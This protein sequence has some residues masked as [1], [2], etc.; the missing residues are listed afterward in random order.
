MLDEIARRPALERA[1]DFTLALCALM[2]LTPLIVLIALAIKVDSRGPVFHRCRRVGFRGREL[3]MLKFR[4][5]SATAAGSSLTAADDD[6]FTRLGRILARTKLDEIPQLFNVLTGRMS[7]VGPRPEDPD[8]VALR[9]DDYER[10][11]QVRPGITGLTQLAFARESE[12]LDASD[13]L[14]DYVR[15]LLPQKTRIDRLY[16]A[17]RSIGMDVRILWWTAINFLFK[18]E[19]A[20]N[21]S[22]G[23]LSLRRRPAQLVPK[24]QADR[25]EVNA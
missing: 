4:K 7:L 18:S 1:L 23:S 2:L 5:M 24:P 3:G 12:I 20:V 16:V 6:R 8:F 21:R 9:R 13:P 10:I 25:V 17:R 15:R 22:T 19:V 11:L 14:G